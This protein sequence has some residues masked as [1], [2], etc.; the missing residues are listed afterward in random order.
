MKIPNA[1]IG[2][3]VKYSNK[4]DPSYRIGGLPQYRRIVQVRGPWGWGTI[5]DQK[6]SDQENG[7]TWSEML[8]IRDFLR[9]YGQL[10]ST[11]NMV[12]QYDEEGSMVF[13]SWLVYEFN[14]N[15]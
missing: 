11:P 7:L 3:E 6:Q 10:R 4:I 15:H 13:S 2:K 9:H 1:L 14:K 12:G 5:Y 8:A